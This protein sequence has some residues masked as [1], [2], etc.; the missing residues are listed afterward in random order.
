MRKVS[1]VL[2][3]AV[4]FG[5]LTGAAYAGQVNGILMTTMCAAKAAKGGPEAASK[6]ERTCNLKPDCAKTGFGGLT[7]ENK[8][9]QFDEAG[10]EKALKA[11]Q[12][13]SKKDD[14]QVVVTGKIQGS[15]I[16]VSTL[17]LVD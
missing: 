14:M 1:K 3:S 8:F 11:L 16:V 17:K 9:F 10:N 12:E 15:E 6:H 2:R 4:L 13:S 7:S 5:A